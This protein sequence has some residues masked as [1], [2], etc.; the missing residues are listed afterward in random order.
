MICQKAS[1][2]LFLKHTQMAGNRLNNFMELK[3]KKWRESKDLAK[4]YRGLLQ[5]V[6]QDPAHHPEGNVLAHVQLVRKAIPRAISELTNLKNSVQFDNILADIDFTI[7][8][9]EFKI[10][11]LAAWLHDIGKASATTIDPKG[12]I[13]S[14]GHQDPE[15]YQPQLEKLRSIAPP[16]VVALYMRNQELVNFLIERHMDFVQKEGFSG[17]FLRTYFSNGKVKNSQ[18]MKLLL[19]L[20]WADKMGRKPEEV[21]TNGIAK[22]VQRLARSSERS[23]AKA[24]NI[25]N[26]TKPFAGTAADMEAMLRQKGLSDLQIQQALKGKFT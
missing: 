20:M 14:I 26:Q 15:H 2:L 9:E 17:S 11:S 22:N 16:D 25:A 4:A 19:V 21:I 8:P 5:D 13:Q 3:F 12:K 10:L 6:P 7:S 18:E 1:G 23:A 24:A